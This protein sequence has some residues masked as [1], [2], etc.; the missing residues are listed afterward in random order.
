MS[1]SFRLSALNLTSVVSLLVDSGQMRVLHSA[2]PEL[3]RCCERLVFVRAKENGKIVKKMKDA[4]QLSTVTSQSPFILA[5]LHRPLTS[6]VGGW[7]DAVHNEGR[8]PHEFNYSFGSTEVQNQGNKSDGAGAG[9][10][11]GA[12]EGA[13]A[14]EDAGDRA[15]EE[16][17]SDE[18]ETPMDRIGKSARRLS[19]AFSSKSGATK[20]APS[21]A[22]GDSVRKSLRLDDRCGDSSEPPAVPQHA[23]SKKQRRERRNYSPT[24]MSKILH[25]WR[26]SSSSVD[27]HASVA[28]KCADRDVD[29]QIVRNIIRTASARYA[30]GNFSD[31]MYGPGC[32]DVM[33]EMN[34]RGILQNSSRK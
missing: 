22:V 13:S 23:G 14:K 28:R 27:V 21:I 3:A 30:N 10:G 1:L 25:L 24:M 11:A 29:A 6:A 2:N 5:D 7:L 31:D 15:E 18:F 9:A 26:D 12:A 32:K 4:N 16:S 20:R 19:E 34:R 33:D 8:F 17:Q